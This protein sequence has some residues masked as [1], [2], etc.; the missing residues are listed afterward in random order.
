MKTTV[1]YENAQWQVTNWGIRCRPWSYEFEKERLGE[2]RPGRGDHISDWLL[3]SAETKAEFDLDLFADALRHAIRIHNIGTGID[4][5]ASLVEAKRIQER[6]KNRKI[7][8]WFA[9][10]IV[11]PKTERP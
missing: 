8:E 11:Y 10:L 9:R 6:S 7:P 3:H 4:V 1:H 2:T 5:D